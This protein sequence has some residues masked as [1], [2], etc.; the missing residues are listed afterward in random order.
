VIAI[1]PIWNQEA[2]LP[3]G[4]PPQ[5]EQLVALA[6]AAVRQSRLSLDAAGHLHPEASVEA[7][8]PIAEAA[9]IDMVAGCEMAR[10][11]YFK[12]AYSLWRGWFE[13]TLFALYFLEA[14]LHRLAWRA[15]EEVA[16][17]AAPASKLMLHQILTLNG[18]K[19]HHFAVVY[20]ERWETVLRAWRL[21]APRDQNPVR[22]AAKRLDDLSQGVHGTY[23]PVP[24]SSEVAL[25]EALDRH[26]LPILLATV[27]LVGF[28]WF[29]H[30]QS[31]LDLTDAQLAGL[32]AP[33]FLPPPG[34]EEE[35]LIPL[36]PQ[37]DLWLDQFRIL[38]E[39]A[40]APAEA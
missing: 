36:L 4:L 14:P 30:V 29:L 17:G 3:E 9:N 28:L 26:V 6:E 20:V 18:D 35:I 39:A 1:R 37:M 8:E 2:A 19:A 13:Q 5:V 25:P 27:R 11:G 38:R 40:A 23:R 32:R 33:G 10:A 24:V 16:L 31:H 12:Q 7:I 22:L 21:S 15:V 34:S